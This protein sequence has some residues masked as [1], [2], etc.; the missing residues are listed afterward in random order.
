MPIVLD[1]IP[2]KYDFLS[3]RAV[4]VSKYFEFENIIRT[5]YKAL[6]YNK[7]PTVGVV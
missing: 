2:K 5:A 1:M 6:G 4:Y 3:E 7:Q